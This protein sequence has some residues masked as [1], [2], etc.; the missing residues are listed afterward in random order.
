MLKD[1]RGQVKQATQGQDRQEIR[2]NEPSDT[3]RTVTMNMV[4]MVLPRLTGLEKDLAM[5]PQKTVSQ[6]RMRTRRS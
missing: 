3:K 5:S 1:R 4:R 2:E 6:T